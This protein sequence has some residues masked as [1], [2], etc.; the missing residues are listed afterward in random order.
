MGFFSK[1]FGSSNSNTSAVEKELEIGMVEALVM[2]G[3]DV[4]EAKK[5]FDGLVSEVKKE[6]SA[7]SP[8]PDNFGDFLL[9]NADR[10]E[11]I[12]QIVEDRR[13]IGVT[14]QEIRMWW[15]KSELERGVIIKFDELYR[16]TVFIRAREQGKSIDEAAAHVRNM[17]ICYGDNDLK[18]DLPYEWKEK[19]DKLVLNV[20]APDP[21]K[22]KSEAE[23]YAEFNDYI[24]AKFDLKSIRSPF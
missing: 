2:Q 17:L 22:T 21:E 24:R 8:L 9:E 23:Q 16:L 3:M 18:V 4:K 12:K 11:K 19:I 14:D 15:N 13:R 20:I 6:I 7:S 5:M 10:N 1:V